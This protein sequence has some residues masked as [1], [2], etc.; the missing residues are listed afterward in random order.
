MEE[1]PR[2]NICDLESS[3]VHNDDVG[4][5]EGV[6]K[7]R[8]PP[9]LFYA[10][11]FW[12]HHLRKVPLMHTHFQNLS[13]FLYTRLLPWLEVMSLLKNLHFSR[14]ALL[15]AKFLGFGDKLSC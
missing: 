15:D 9:Q 10:C 14:P 8:I 3:C 7:A 11:N 1:K 5:L 12:A 4:G 13:T 2:F 6:I